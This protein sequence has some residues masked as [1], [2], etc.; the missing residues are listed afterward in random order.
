MLA[1][2]NT[3]DLGSNICLLY[4]MPKIMSCSRKLHMIIE[5]IYIH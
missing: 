3:C 2:Q 1:R 5:S 4:Y